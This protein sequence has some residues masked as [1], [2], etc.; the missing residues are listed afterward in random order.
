ML[1]HYSHKRGRR[2]RAFAPQ[3]G[4]REEGRLCLIWEAVSMC[5]CVGRL[6]RT[7]PAE[8]EAPG[9]AAWPPETRHC[10]RVGRQQERQEAP[11]DLRQVGRRPHETCETPSSPV[12]SATFPLL[13]LAA[14]RQSGRATGAK[15]QLAWRHSPGSEP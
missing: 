3:G 2:G 9:V 8:T 11:R 10:K 5:A 6:R 1:S 13:V 14:H 15:H 7:T 12:L 4:R